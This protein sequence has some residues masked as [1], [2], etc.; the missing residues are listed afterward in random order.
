MYDGKLNQPSQL[1]AV[2]VTHVRVKLFP[3]SID[4]ATK[5]R[6]CIN[7][8]TLFLA[9]SPCTICARFLPTYPLYPI[10]RNGRAYVRQNTVKYG[11]R[12]QGINIR[13]AAHDFIR[14]W[15]RIYAPYVLEQNCLYFIS[16]STLISRELVFNFTPLTLLVLSLSLLLQGCLSAS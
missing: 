12:K 15:S 5:K 2:V 6:F 1:V 10:T 16:V 3:E 9:Q 11:Y 4:Q 13:S 14:K 8:D 7:D